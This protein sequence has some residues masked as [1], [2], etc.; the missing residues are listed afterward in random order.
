MAGIL[1]SRIYGIQKTGL[2]G[3]KL[4]KTGP[5]G[6]ELGTCMFICIYVLC[7]INLYILFNHGFYSTIKT[8]TMVASLWGDCAEGQMKTPAIPK[9][10]SH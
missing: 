10:T 1:L 5:T 3:A 6:V 8:L 9:V 4:Q 7:L 2:T